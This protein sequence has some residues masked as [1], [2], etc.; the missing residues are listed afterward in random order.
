MRPGPEAIRWIDSHADALSSQLQRYK[1]PSTGEPVAPS[2][3]GPLYRTAR[4]S[5]SLADLEQILR[6]YPNSSMARRTGS[7]APQAQFF[8]TQLH[9][10]IGEVR[11]GTG[12]NLWRTSEE[13]RV[14]AAVLGHAMRELK[15]HR[16][17]SS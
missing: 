3:V 14:L 11:T 17:H 16:K 8:V 4:I 1:T 9:W 2:V 7:S 5:T 13:P 10:L 12:Q 6:L 15:G